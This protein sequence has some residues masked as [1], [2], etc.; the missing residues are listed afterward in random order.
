MQTTKLLI[1]RHGNTFE[2]DELPRRV[3]CR[4]D[5]PLVAKG[6]QQAKDLALHLR[7]KNLSPDIIYSSE[8]LRAKQTAE[9]IISTLE[10]DT[11]L[12]IFN[13]FNEID[14]GPDENKTEDEVISRI[15]E[16]Q[17]EAWNKDAIVPNGWLVNPE[18][19]IRDWQDFSQMCLIQ[20]LGKTVLVVTSN[21]IA[22]FSPHITDNFNEFALNHQ[23]KLATGAYSCF[24][25]S[26][27]HKWE[28]TEWNIKP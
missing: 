11:T 4:T 27:N 1:C 7:R 5:L 20:H 19:I 24:E 14:Y 3:G 16:A 26:N 10:L 8:L 28:V 6:K 2:S 13:S 12:N 21:G 18:K 25:N 17:L 22:R 15:S 23:I 9:E